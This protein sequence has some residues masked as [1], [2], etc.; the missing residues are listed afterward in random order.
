[1]FFYPKDNTLVC[2]MQMT[3]YNLNHEEYNNYKIQL[4]GINTGSVLEHNTFCSNHG[5]KFPILSDNNKNVSEQFKALNIF[6]HNK[7]KLVLIGTDK[8]ILF[9]KTVFSIF[10]LDSIR[11]IKSLKELKII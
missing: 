7:R 4:I 8:R 6:G 10:Y 5:F 3:D 11:I 1:M 9:E 2:S